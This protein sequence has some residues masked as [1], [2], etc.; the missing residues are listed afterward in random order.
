MKTVEVEITG[1]SPIL[2]H[3][4][5]EEAEREVQENTRRSTRSSK[6][7]ETPREKAEKAAYRLKDGRLYFPGVGIQRSFIEAARYFKEKGARGSLKFIAA[8]AFLVRDE[9]IPF[10][11]GK[12]EVKDFEVDCRPVVIPST[13]GRVMRFRPRLDEWALRFTV[14][15]DDEIISTKIA[16]EILVTAGNRIGIGDYRPE[17][18]GPFGR[19]NVTEWKEV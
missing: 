1:K 6:D 7:E 17:K 13:K 8:A 16:N 14:D 5:S 15:I 3:R 11:N 2:L 18:R 19:F 10:R 12:A 9:A 4:F